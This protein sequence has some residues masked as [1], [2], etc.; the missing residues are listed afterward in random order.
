MHLIGLPVDLCARG[1][2]LDRDIQALEYEND[3]VFR[4]ILQGQIE[5]ITSDEILRFLQ[6]IDHE[7]C[8]DCACAPIF[9][10]LTITRWSSV[11]VLTC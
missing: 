8:D 10:M 6:S 11:A 4:R 7:Q 1:I 3:W 5:T 2:A 9:A